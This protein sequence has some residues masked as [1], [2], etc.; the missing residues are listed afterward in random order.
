MLSKQGTQSSKGN[1]EER[2]LKANAPIYLVFYIL[3]FKKEKRL[4]I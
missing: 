2:Q 1:C 4:L 3:G